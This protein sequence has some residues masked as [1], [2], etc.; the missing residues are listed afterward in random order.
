MPPDTA[1]RGRSN[2]DCSEKRQVLGRRGRKYTGEL[3]GIE[4]VHAPEKTAE[5]IAVFGKDG[6]VAVLEQRSMRN[7]DLFAHDASPFQGSTKNPIGA[8]VAV[9]GATVAVLPEGAAELAQ[10][11]HHGI[12]PGAAHALG[13]GGEPAAELLQARGEVAA[14]AA[15]AHVGVPAADVDEA[16]VVLAL[17]EARDAPRLQLEAARV[18]GVAARSLHLAG[19]VAHHALAHREALA[20][21]RTELGVAVHLGNERALARVDGRGLHA[22]GAE[23]DVGDRLLATT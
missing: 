15:L 8:A 2:D 6:I 11:H 16:E 5:E 10:H 21:R 23:R 22:S 9:V 19:E 12:A 7:A 4:A 20:H 3:R 17:H 1:G 13:E 18:D 14:R